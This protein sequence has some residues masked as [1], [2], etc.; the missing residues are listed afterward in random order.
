MGNRLHKGLILTALYFLGGCGSPAEPTPV[1]IGHPA[2]LSG[3]DKAIGESARRGIQLAVEEANQD[4]EKGARRP[5]RVRHTD[6]QGNPEAFGAEVARLI[7]V[8]TP[9]V[10]ALI[11][12]LNTEE[13]KEFKRLDRG[14]VFLVSPTGR[15]SESAGDN[16]VFYTGLSA[17]QQGAALARLAAE[18]GFA[19]VIV[20]VN[21]DEASGRSRILADTFKD[22][23][24]ELLV[25][26]HP[27]RK[28]A[29]AGPRRYGKANPIRKRAEVLKKE[30]AGTDPATKPDA[31]L[32]AGQPS[33]VKTLCEEL[34]PTRLPVL[35]G[36]TEGS[37]R[38]LLEEQ[39]TGNGVYLATAFAPDG[40]SDAIKEFV[41]KYKKRFGEEPDVSAALAYDDVRLLVAALRQ[42]RTADSDLIR[43]ALA[44]VRDFPSLTGPLGFDKNQQAQRD[45][46]IVRTAGGKAA[47]VKR[48]K[49]D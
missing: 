22:R 1:W 15:V 2:P 35:F 47:L 11:G 21:E 33:D 44:E 18:E 6:S 28:P 39:E 41:Q 34:G 24:P 20:L 30:L 43:K 29:V 23:F 17:A 37:L 42:A 25:K 27:K 12:G 4:S 10:L 7:N 48:Y 16:S 36:G 26:K 45:V 9:R 46:F 14:G 13:I 31:I 49:A 40:A 38:E 8:N 32:V 3:P 5:V 19:R